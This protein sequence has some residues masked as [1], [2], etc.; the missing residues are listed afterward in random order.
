MF[1]AW[2]SDDDDDDD[3]DDDDNDDGCVTFTSQYII[4]IMRSQ[5]FG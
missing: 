2:N 5:S 4:T 3:N 1:S